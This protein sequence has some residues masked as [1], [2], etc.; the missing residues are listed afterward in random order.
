MK[1]K[2]IIT[3]AILTT[4]MLMTACGSTEGST[5]VE[6]G[7]DT[8]TENT[9][10]STAKADDAPTQEAASASGETVEIVYDILQNQRCFRIKPYKG[11]V[12]KQKLRPVHQGGK[13]R[14]LL[15][16]AVGICGDQISQRF[17]N[18]KCIPILCDSLPSLIRRYAEQVGYEIQ[19]LNAGKIFVQIRIVRNIGKLSLTGNR[20]LS[21]ILP[22][23]PY[24]PTV[25]ILNACHT[26]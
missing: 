15:F 8:G 18:L 19:L 3:A 6:T 11:F 4:A 9:D 22:A 24:R 25:E 14:Q 12:Q 2:N 13:D 7:S 20:L 10:A 5:S 26:F 23:D 1:K 21:D 17:R 16:H